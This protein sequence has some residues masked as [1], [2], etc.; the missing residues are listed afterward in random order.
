MV[1]GAEVLVGLDL[2]RFGVVDSEALD[3]IHS[4]VADLEA[5]VDGAVASVDG[6]V[7]SVDGAV[8]S[9][10]GAVVSV[11]GTPTMLVCGI[12]MV[13]SMEASMV[14]SL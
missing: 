4:G 12:L 10:D 6:A 11:D 5:S 1:D 7:A 9:V 3:M 2:I 8:A 14:E 13:A